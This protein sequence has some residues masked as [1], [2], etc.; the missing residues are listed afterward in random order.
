MASLK[1]IRDRIKS[2][3]SIQ[4]VTSAMKMVSAAKVRRAQEKMEQARPYTFALEEVIHHILPD[5]DRADLDLLQVREIKRKAYVIVSADRGLA[6]AFNS[7]ILKISE[8]EI[9]EF[10]KEN[11]DLFCIGKKARDH[12]KK[13]NY[14]IIESH[15]DFWSELDYDNAMMIGRSIIDHFTTGKVDEIHVVYNYF[16]NMAQQEVRSEVLLPLVYEEQESESLDKLYEPSK[17]DLVHSLIPRHLN[18]QFGNIYLN[19]IRVSRQ[20]G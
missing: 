13:R 2:V 11:V 16:V 18:I 20:Q 3:K 12:F 6:G 19:L 15:I 14:N 4:K 17:K 10:G 7:N 1:D 9:A 8:K 5:I